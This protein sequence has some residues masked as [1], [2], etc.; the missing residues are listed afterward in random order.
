MSTT[1]PQ[2]FVVC[3]EHSK[4]YSASGVCPDCDG[5]GPKGVDYSTAQEVQI[6]DMR[7]DE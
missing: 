2:E 7:V 3:E 1:T 5:T 4:L 6:V